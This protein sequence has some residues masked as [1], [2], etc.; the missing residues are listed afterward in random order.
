MRKTNLLLVSGM[1]LAVGAIAAVAATPRGPRD[2]AW[3]QS[4]MPGM[5]GMRARMRGMFA[6][7][8]ITADEYDART[9]ERFARLDKNS[10]GVLD[11]AEIEAALA[12]R[13]RRGRFGSDSRGQ[14]AE[15]LLLRFGDKDGKITKDA[16]LAEAKRRF[17]QLDLNNDGK[18]TDDDLPP[19]MRGKGVLKSTGPAGSGPRGNGFARLRAADTKGDGV[20]T[21]DAFIAAETKRFDELDRN[22]DG[23]ID[24]ADFA[25]LRKEM[26]DYGVKRFLHAYGADAEG[27]VTRDQFYK[28][29]KERFARL[30]RKGEGRI[31]LDGRGRN[32]DTPGR[33]WRDRRSFGPERGQQQPQQPP[34]PPKQ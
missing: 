21:F 16:F 19:L 7:R 15:R 28:I 4:G 25:A 18:I 2:G 3:G 30:D 26:V 22:R 34:I 12:E 24:N 17:A 14:P 6:P 1:V 32:P 10:D 11:A 29:A 33:E 31:F 8:A 13:G 5:D 9:R 23:V 27:K 20:I